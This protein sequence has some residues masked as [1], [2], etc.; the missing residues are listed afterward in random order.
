[1]HIQT[2]WWKDV[3]NLS[4]CGTKFTKAFQWINA[5]R[6]LPL[7]QGQTA[8]G[9]AGYLSPISFYILKDE[10][11]MVNWSLTTICIIHYTCGTAVVLRCHLYW[12]LYIT[13]CI[14]ILNSN[15][16]WQYFLQVMKYIISKDENNYDGCPAHYI[17][18][19]DHFHM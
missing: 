6:M 12:I 14:S 2:P 13:R 4:K 11:R 9:V 3:G 15:Y 10:K 18:E 7:L 5:K 16:I 19:Q 8:D 1:M 17:R